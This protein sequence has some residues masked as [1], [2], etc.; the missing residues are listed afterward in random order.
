MIKLRND[1]LRRKSYNESVQMLSIKGADCLATSAGFSGRK[2][3]NKIMFH[4]L[5][6]K[7]T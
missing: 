5:P 3:K 4:D 1:K 2:C 7:Y 6:G